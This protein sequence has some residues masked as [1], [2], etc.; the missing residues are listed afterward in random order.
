[1]S[2]FNPVNENGWLAAPHQAR[3]TDL[4]S[5][6]VCVGFSAMSLSQGETRVPVAVRIISGLDQEGWETARR[7]QKGENS[8]V[9]HISRAGHWTEHNVSF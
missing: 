4:R 6:M 7:P 3:T 1:M 5:R 9:L 8:T 2:R